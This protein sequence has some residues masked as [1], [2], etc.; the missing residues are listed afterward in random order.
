MTDIY[1]DNAATS[2]PKP[3][4]VLA[5]IED[6]LVHA[7]G[8]T[9]RSGHRRSIASSRVVSLARE[10][11]ADLLGADSPDDLAFTKNATEALNLALLGLAD[12]VERV[13]TTSLEHNSVMRPLRALEQ[14]GRCTVEVVPADGHTGEVDLDAWAAR[15]RAPGRCLAV[16][17]HASNVTGVLL[18]VE[19]MAAAAAAAG[20]PFVVDASQS[21]GHVPLDLAKLGASAVA[22]PGHKGLLGPTG[23][24]LLYVAPGVEVEPLM[25]G[26]TGSRSE[27]EHQPDFPPDRFESGTLNGMG[28]AGLGAAA[29][30]LADLGVER[31]RARLAAL[32]RRFRAALERADG[33]T[34]HGPADADRNVGIVSLVVAG[35]P[36]ATVARLLDDEWGVMTRAG[37]HCSPAAHRSLGTAPEGT[38]RFSWSHETTEREVDAAAEAVRAIAAGARTPGAVETAA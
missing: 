20:V 29:A 25:R 33:V 30:Y 4:S 12:G 36:C 38:V 11:L 28:I 3:P 16:A 13:V 23:T 17:V 26:G 35:V 10:R 31:V 14:R 2:W 18:P 9:G 5:A 8:N 21:A 24:G 32:T 1:L 27:S 22:M 6:F 15:L 19:A 7:G 34:L 37:L